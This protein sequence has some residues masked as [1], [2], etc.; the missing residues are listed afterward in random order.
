MA[1]RL[2]Q[3][4]TGPSIWTVHHHLDEVDSTND[5]VRRRVQDGAPAGIVVTADEQTAGRGRQGRGWLGVRGGS[6]ALSVGIGVPARGATLVPLAAGLAVGDMLRRRGLTPQLKWPN[7]TFV[8]GRKLGGILAERHRLNDRVDFLVVGIG[9]NVDWRD[10]VTTGEADAWTSIAEELGQDVDIDVVT[11]ELLR[12]LAAWLD[13]VPKDPTRLLAA[14]KV[15]CVT[16]GKQVRADTPR[17]VV[18]GR[19]IDVDPNGALVLDGPTG[20]TLL[21]AADVHHDLT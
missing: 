2:T 13:D 11:V 19:A 9:L 17:G 3:Y 12:A 16:L 5:E 8:G 7:D 4:L 18:E 14:Y 1:S 20:R 6:L 21:T 10:V 15:R